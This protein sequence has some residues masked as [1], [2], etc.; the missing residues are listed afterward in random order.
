M[1]EPVWFSK[2]TG[3]TVP[4]ASVS[5]S[6]SAIVDGFNL[7]G[8]GLACGITGWP[9]LTVVEL[10]F[11]PQPKQLGHRVIDAHAS[12]PHG[13]SNTEIAAHL[14]ELL[15]GELGSVVSVKHQPIRNV[16]AEVYAP[17]AGPVRPGKYL[18]HYP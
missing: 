3:L 10:G 5:A 4:S 15:D 16:T 11:K 14:P 6:A 9:A 12:T 8:N 7:V 18:A 13:L 1:V 17:S 2:S